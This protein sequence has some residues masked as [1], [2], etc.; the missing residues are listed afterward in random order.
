MA[1]GGSGDRGALVHWWK[2]D[3]GRPKKDTA[4]VIDTGRRILPTITADDPEAGGR[5]L[6]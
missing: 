1:D 6:E 2:L 4:L 5:I 3:P